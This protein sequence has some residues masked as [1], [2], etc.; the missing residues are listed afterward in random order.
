MRGN[1]EKAIENYKLTSTLYRNHYYTW[2]DMF[3]A[4]NDLAKQRKVNLDDMRH[5]LDMVRETGM[6]QPGLSAKHIA[7]MEA[8]YDDLKKKTMP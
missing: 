7:G 4:Y 6:G 1:L 8:I 5:A 2:H 3:L